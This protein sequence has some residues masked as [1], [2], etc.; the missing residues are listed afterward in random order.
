M[1]AFSL[2]QSLPTELFQDILELLDK[3]DLCRL[4]LTSRWSYELA[5]P[6]IWRELELTDRTSETHSREDDAVDEHDD[7]PM[8]KKLLVIVQ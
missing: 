2:L 6:L 8:L 5:T 1:A 3:S 7:T 4:N